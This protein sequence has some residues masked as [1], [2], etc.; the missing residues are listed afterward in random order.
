MKNTTQFDYFYQK[1]EVVDEQIRQ[2][3]EVYKQCI[4]SRSR[5]RFQ[6]T[7]DFVHW[8]SRLAKKNR[9]S[10]SDGRAGADIAFPPDLT[11]TTQ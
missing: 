8:D 4:L 6:V 1:R 9:H 5:I 10:Y 7:G 11:N 3:Y 2:Q